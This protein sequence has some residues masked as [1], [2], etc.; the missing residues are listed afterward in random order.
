MFL[1]IQQILVTHEEIAADSKQDVAG[2]SGIPPRARPVPT[3]GLQTLERLHTLSL[4]AVTEQCLS[5]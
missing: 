5:E 3:R 1:A 2:L 4:T